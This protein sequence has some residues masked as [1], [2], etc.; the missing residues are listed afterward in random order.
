[1]TRLVLLALLLLPGLAI[2]ATRRLAPGD[3]LAAAVAAA[4][5]GNDGCKW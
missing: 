3:D 2:A 1:M 4:A 5:A